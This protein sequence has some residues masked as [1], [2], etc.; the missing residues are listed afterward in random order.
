MDVW[1]TDITADDY[2]TRQGLLD[3]TTDSQDDSPDHIKHKE[4]IVYHR[5]WYILFLF[6]L[7]GFTQGG[8]WNTWGPIAD[9]AEK[10]FG[11][12][13]GTIA[14]MANWGPITYVIG[15]GFF[16]W[17]M[18]VKGEYRRSSHLY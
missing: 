10:V 13:D 14:L 15:I 4:V 5:R 7:V 18:D 17:L 6:C 11:W 16:T 12:T 2:E 3:D 9:S 1:S 8:L